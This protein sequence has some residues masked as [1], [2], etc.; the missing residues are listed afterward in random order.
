MVL[1]GRQPSREYTWNGIERLPTTNGEL[2]ANAEVL[3]YETNA[4][5]KVSER[6]HPRCGNP[7]RLERSRSVSN[8]DVLGECKAPPLWKTCADDVDTMWRACGNTRDEKKYLPILQRFPRVTPIAQKPSHVV[9]LDAT[10]RKRKM[11]PAR[12]PL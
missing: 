3:A 1:I 5:L 4:A 6:N 9:S 2:H 7:L 12:P 8:D 11:R 10:C